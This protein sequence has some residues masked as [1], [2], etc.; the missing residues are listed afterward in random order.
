MKGP[1]EVMPQPTAKTPARKGKNSGL[2]AA[3]GRWPQ[4]ARIPLER[5]SGT[6]EPDEQPDQ[7]DNDGQH[8]EFHQAIPLYMMRAPT[9][10]RC[11]PSATARMAAAATS[12]RA[13]TRRPPAFAS[14]A[15]PAGSHATTASP[16]AARSNLHFNGFTWPHRP[17]GSS[18]HADRA[19]RRSPAS[20]RPAPDRRRR[21]PRLPARPWS[22]RT[23]GRPAPW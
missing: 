10:P 14:F 17:S 22:R 18:G 7:A 15:L 2:F 1:R 19:V 5:W 4:G 12:S 8:Q 23:A 3:P 9:G 11:S 13:R 20:A 16:M 6:S 21:V